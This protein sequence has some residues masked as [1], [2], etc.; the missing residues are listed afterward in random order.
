[1]RSST[2]LDYAPPGARASDSRCGVAWA[3][4]SVSFA[5]LAWMIGLPS[6]AWLSGN[7]AVPHK[8]YLALRWI[9]VA[10]FLVAGPAAIVCGVV[11][12]IR[13]T[14]RRGIAVA[15]CILGVAAFFVPLMFVWFR[16]LADL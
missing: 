16:W 5:A 1:M 9:P 13:R 6:Y 3:M 4:A 8:V 7:P 14:P 2:P 15:G 10:G 12:L 11:A